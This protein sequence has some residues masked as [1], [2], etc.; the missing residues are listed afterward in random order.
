MALEFVKS[1]GKDG[2]KGEGEEKTV[3]AEGEEKKEE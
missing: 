1:Q 2:K 3:E